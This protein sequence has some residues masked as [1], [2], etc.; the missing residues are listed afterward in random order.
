MHIHLHSDPTIREWLEAAERGDLARLIEGLDR[1]ISVD[2]TSEGGRTALMLAAYE[3][4]ADAAR[5]LIDRGA[6]VHAIGRDGRTPLAWA[7]A[8]GR[9]EVAAILRAAGATE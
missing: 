1:G 2:T 9:D 8:E 4:H 6:D 3:G 7:I 5:F